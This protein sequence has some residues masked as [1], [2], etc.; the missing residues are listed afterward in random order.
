MTSSLQ[1]LDVADLQRRVRDV[2]RQVAEQPHQSYHFEMGRELALR[3]GYPA[4]LLDQAPAEAVESFA[5]VGCFL[6]LA[7]LRTGERVLDLGS[8]SGTDSF[9]S[10]ILVGPAGKVTRIDM[11]PAQRARADRLA[12]LRRL[13]Q[14]LTLIQR[15]SQHIRPSPGP[16]AAAAAMRLL[17]VATVVTATAL[18]TFRRRDVI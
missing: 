12:G 4:E 8:G 9:A 18:V 15:S 13:R 17:A 7:A 1:N 14:A 16:G 6:D 11:T 5:G 2:Y 10:A 3:L